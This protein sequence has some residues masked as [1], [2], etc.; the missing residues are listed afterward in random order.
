[1]AE[2]GETVQPAVRAWLKPKAEEIFRGL[3]TSLFYSGRVIGK[4]V[5]ICSA[6]RREGTSTI[7]AGVALA[8]SAPSGVARVALVD[9]NLR[10]PAMHEILGL[11]PA[12]G[13]VEVIVGGMEPRAVAQ[14]VTPTLD[15]F[16]SGNVGGRLLD[17]LRSDALTGFLNALCEAYDHV[18]IDAPAANQFPDA[19]VLATAAKNV[20]LVAHTEQTPREAVAQAK[21]RL[22]AGGGR[23]VGLVLNM[24][25]YPIPGFLYRRV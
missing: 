22:E 10:Y 6:D 18:L 19:H 7:T 14:Q 21:K 13:V 12:P 20:V 5:V 3:W 24:R 16:A 25:T 9:F 2:P 4:S 8:G 1:M 11:Q 15:L 17:V 23:L